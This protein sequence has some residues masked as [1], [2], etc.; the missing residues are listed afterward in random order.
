MLGQLR[1]MGVE[2]GSP[3]RTW[4][5]KFFSK[6]S[7]QEPETIEGGPHPRFPVQSVG[8]RKLHALSLQKGAHAVVSRA[9]SR[10]FGYLARFSRDVGYREP[11]P[12][13]SQNP[14]T[15][16]RCSRHVPHRSPFALLWQTTTHFVKEITLPIDTRRVTLF[17]V[18]S[19]VESVASRGYLH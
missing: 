6:L 3:K 12:R 5:Q 1:R 17:G 18:C 19:A 14:N 11:Q 10:K 2:S 8:F 9:A 7:L 16:G 4:D 13:G 15:K